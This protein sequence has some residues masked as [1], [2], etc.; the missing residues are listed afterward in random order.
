MIIN[1]NTDIEGRFKKK[2][3]LLCSLNI[4]KLTWLWLGVTIFIELIL[5]TI[6]NVVGKEGVLNLLNSAFLIVM[7]SSYLHYTNALGEF[8]LKLYLNAT[9][10]ENSNDH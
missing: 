9:T 6:E 5:L 7:F 3:F 8:L 4:T 1:A 2:L 10:E